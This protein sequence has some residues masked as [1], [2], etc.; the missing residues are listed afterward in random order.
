MLKLQENQS[1]SPSEEHSDEHAKEEDQLSVILQMSSVAN[2]EQ[3]QATFTFAAHLFIVFPTRSYWVMIVFFH[4]DVSYSWFK[5]GMVALS[6]GMKSIG[7]VM[8]FHIEI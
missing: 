3:K 6:S 7:S 5:Q 4:T 1:L 8:L 2:L